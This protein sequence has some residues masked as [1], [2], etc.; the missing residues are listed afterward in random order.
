M[1]LEEV[2]SVKKLM[3]LLL[4]VTL[5]CTALPMA[6]ATDVEITGPGVNFR[7]EPKGTVITRFGGGEVLPALDEIWSHDQLWYQV[8]S[9]QYGDGYVSGEWARPVWNGITIY[10]PD[11]PEKLKYVTENVESFYTDLYRFLYDHGYCY[12]NQEE[13]GTTFRVSNGIGDGS[14]V[15]P[16]H[17]LDLALMLLKNGLLVENGDTAILM[18]E[19]STEEEKMQAASLLLR[20]HYGTED[21][22]E[23]LIQRGVMDHAEAHV[24]HGI[25]ENED[26]WKLAAVLDRVSREYTGPG[27]DADPPSNS[28]NAQWYINPNGGSKLHSDPYC[29]SVHEKYL[30]LQKTELTNEIVQ[31]YSLCPVCSSGSQ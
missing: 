31:Q 29:R 16:K 5:F 2:L 15:Q 1:R 14:V 22:W 24:P 8:R 27:D 12:W 3:G 13:G 25:L 23:I 26:V 17:K 7:K 21:M 6:L 30:P 19:T 18:N 4:S 9:D 28:E 20:R 10:D 11:H